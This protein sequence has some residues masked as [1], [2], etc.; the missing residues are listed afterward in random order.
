[1][2]LP[3]AL[4]RLP[5]GRIARLGLACIGAVTLGF[6]LVCGA[7][8]LD[9]R[10]TATAQAAAD[11]RNIAAGVAQEVARNLDL[12]DL[13]LE[14][15]V[16]GLQFPGL[17]T[18][19]PQ[20]RQLILFGR[21]AKAPYFSVITAIEETGTVIAESGSVIPRSNDWAAHDYFT[22]Q[23]DDARDLLFIGAP[24]VTQPG[25]PSS[26][27]ISR[28]MSHPDGSFAGVVVGTMPLAYFHDL[29]AN[30]TLGPHATIE[31][32][33]ADGMI[34]MRLPFAPADVGRTLPSNAP[35]FRAP[36]GG[37]VDA[38]DPTDHQHR[39]FLFRR[40][41]ALPLVVGVGL[42]DSDIYAAWRGKA[43]AIGGVVAAL[44]A[45]DMLLLLVV[46]YALVRWENG[47]AALRGDAEAATLAAQREKAVAAEVQ[48]LAV[49]TRFLAIMSHELR[50][51]LNSIA[52]YAELL[53]LDG[54]LEPLQAARIA[55][56]RS[57]GDHLRDV[58]NRVFDF[59]RV[60][61][62][63][64]PAPTAP[65]DLA[66]LMEQCR[67]I[68][69]PIAAAKG[70]SLTCTV[71][72]A[73]PLRVMA[74]AGSIR[75][76]LLNLLGNAIRSTDHGAVTLRITRGAGG[77]RFVV[78]DTGIGIPAVQRE[79][80]FQPHDRLDADRLSVLGAGL[81]L[82]I[83]AR[84]V[85]RMDGHIGHED[86]PLGGSVFWVELPLHPV[87]AEQSVERATT[88]APPSRPLRVLLADDSAL[89]RDV[90]VA[91]LHTAGHEVVEAADGDEALRLVVDDMFDVILMDLHM[92]LI[93]GIE[94]T[95]HIR[96][97]PGRRGETPIIAITADVQEDHG[98]A[99]RAA[100]FQAWL[101]K[102]IDL[103]SL[104]AAV[105]AAGADSAL[106][107]SPPVAASTGDPPMPAPGTPSLAMPIVALP[108]PG[109]ATPDMP[110]AKMPIATVPTPTMTVQF[111][112]GIAAATVEHHLETF[113]SQLVSLLDLLDD[114]SGDWSADCSTGTSAVSRPG[115]SPSGSSPG[116]P[117]KYSSSE[118]STR[119]TAV[120]SPDSAR[121]ELAHRIA[122]DGGQLGLT[123]LSA[124]ARRYEVAWHAGD[125]QVPELAAALRDM[126]GN[127]LKALRQRRDFMR[128]AAIGSAKLP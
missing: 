127:A 26:I 69:E 125:T 58:V 63:D 88:F 120:P 116:S 103:M 128:R 41:G 102:P 96:A 15:V 74:D 124:A 39:R 46:R 31:L 122:G 43:E 16:Q 14:A 97:L 75:Q 62:D 81:G 60:E 107:P 52:G 118:W 93:D 80:Q 92:P 50:T 2:T 33:R 73:V 68:V 21:A 111:P 38:D 24:F 11:A 1:M 106:V 3:G 53:S 100:G 90:A 104:L 5:P 126:A 83:A 108:I 35:F 98:A 12:Y 45:I 51:P 27:P 71:A 101:I 70:V 121:A 32:L 66:A 10:R 25:Q 95:R 55:A 13:S 91:Y 20:L 37:A 89:N 61:T 65:T 94:A 22:A 119:R 17:K 105:A 44:A 29:F 47:L 18:L 48:A 84:L 114:G 34:L 8:V 28:R 78:T 77:T 4:A 87:T 57:A 112:A 9:A 115:L 76:V 82:A 110:I 6:I 64:R 85:A 49:K 117:P 56:M 30:L 59:S 23:R 79:R 72:P 86:N 19:D 42:A 40:I 113:A 7:V 109:M 99:L 36:D 67:T 54:K 123:A